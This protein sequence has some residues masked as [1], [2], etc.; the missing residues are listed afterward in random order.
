[1]K[2]NRRGP[3]RVRREGPVTVIRIYRPAVRNAIDAE[4]A[5]ALRDAW[6]AF[7][8]DDEAKVG[9]LTGGDDLFSAGADLNDLDRLAPAVQSEY[10]PL[11]FTRLHIDKPTIAAVAGYCVAGGL[12]M[13]RRLAAF[14]QICLRRDRLA[15]YEGLGRPLEEGLRVEAR[16]GAAVLE[17][18][19]PVAGARQFLEE[20]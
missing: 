4:T 5:A 12:E 18:G 8:H 20:E 17:S 9:V 1:M 14:P 6:L 7:A 15:V 13:A 3:V 11:G 16:H 10:G 19:E 2:S